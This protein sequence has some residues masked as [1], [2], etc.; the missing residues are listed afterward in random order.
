MKIDHIDVVNLLFPI[1]DNMRFAYSGGHLTGRLTTL[2]RVT[3]N[4]GIIGIGAA[5]GHPMLIRT[6]IE[7]HLAPMLIGE[8]PVEVETLWHKMYRLTRWYGRKGVA[9]SALGALDTAFWDLR[10]KAQG[11]P[12]YALLG[13]TRNSVPAYAS[14]LLWSDDIDG[15]A[16]EAA[17]YVAQGYRRVKMR[18]GKSEAYDTAAVRAVRQSVGSSVGVIVD[19]SMRYSLEVAERMAALLE[20]LDVFWYEEPFEPDD[21]DNY[22]ALR[23]RIS[24]PIAAGENEF[25]VE[26]FRELLRA[27]AVDVVQPDACRAGGI[28]AC[29]QVGVMAAQY[30]ASVG[31]HTWSDAVAL[32]ANAHVVASLPNGLSVEVD[33]TGNP[34]IDD[35]LMEPL[36][37]RD[38]LLHLAD[39]PGLGIAL[40]QDTVDRYTLPPDQPIPDWAYSDMSFGKIYDVDMA[41]YE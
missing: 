7:H 13:G 24:V 9:I 4:H 22:V 1:T 5:Y 11:K 8:D 31:P 2:V 32:T 3:T 10:G 27:A 6:I 16:A 26:G 15:L 41:P 17:G 33:R 21:I 40:N 37:I 39:A 34:F 28:T 23:Q 30:G 29:H 19:A 35:L 38:G 25:G 36:D 12:V 18:L 20:E 14:A